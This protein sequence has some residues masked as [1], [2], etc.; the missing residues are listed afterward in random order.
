MSIAEGE[1][2]DG[3]LLNGK[4]GNNGMFSKKFVLEMFYGAAG[5]TRR[6]DWIAGYR[7]GSWIMAEGVFGA[8]A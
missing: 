7:K 6:G 3:W 8:A 2:V 4:R 1:E 5:N